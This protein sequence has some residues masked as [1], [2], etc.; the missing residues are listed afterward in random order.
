MKRIEGEAR[1]A[2]IGFGRGQQV[3]E[4]AGLTVDPHGVW[5]RF[6]TNRAIGPC[7]ASA[8]AVNRVQLL[9]YTVEK[10]K[11]FYFDYVNINKFD[12]LMIFYLNNILAGSMAGDS[13][14]RE[15]PITSNGRLATIKSDAFLRGVRGLL[16]LKLWENHHDV[17]S[18]N[19]PNPGRHDRIGTC[20]PDFTLRGGRS[21]RGRG[22][23]EEGG[24]IIFFG[25]SLTYLA[26]EEKPKE[27][28]TKGYV[29]I[30]RETLQ[31]KH[32]DKN[33]EVDWVATGGH[34]VPDL[35]K[36]V[37]KDVIAKKPTIVVIQIGCNDARRIPK[38][39]FQTEPGGA[40]R[41][42][43][44]GRASRWSSAR[45]PASARSTTARTRTTPSWTSSPRSSAK[46]PRRRRSRS[47]TCAR[48]SS[49][50][51]RRTTPTTS[52]AAS[53]PTT[54]TTSTTPGMEFVAEQMLKKL[55]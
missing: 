36:R 32:K 19:G 51:G 25:D 7:S 29:R 30:V 38:E 31:E 49:P 23:A 54:A 10:L 33:I 18:P 12:Y 37:D 42:A 15:N 55:K 53:S 50:T 48:R 14:T 28:V 21:R 5:Q 43:A 45:S 17:R 24:P 34:T 11:N 39:T 3:S 44:E 41:Q 35:L 22:R 47:T 9:R 52:R 40:D 26:G 2:L 4:A 6:A 16:G 20:V 27:H 46:S 1:D 8:T 13:R